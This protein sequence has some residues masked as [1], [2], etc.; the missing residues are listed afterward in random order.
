MVMKM[1]LEGRLI[2]V[3]P[4][5]PDKI[6]LKGYIQRLQDILRKKYESLLAATR[7]QPFFYIEVP[8]GIG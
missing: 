6:K 8:S 2:A 5:E 7:K 3:L 1:I 4:L